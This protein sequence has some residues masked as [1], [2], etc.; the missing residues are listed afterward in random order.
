LR[1]ASGYT[2]PVRIFYQILFSFIFFFLLLTRG[3]AAGNFPGDWGI[4]GE[5]GVQVRSF[6]RDPNFGVQEH[7]T[8]SPSITMEV[9]L[10]KEWNNGRDRF[11][12]IPFGR[13]DAHDDQRSRIEIKELHWTHQ[14][15]DWSLLL[16]ISK[17]FWGVTESRHLVDIIN[18]TDSSA[19][20]DGEDKLGQPMINLTLER[21][22]G[23]I[24]LFLLPYFRE[25]IF[26]K[27]DARLKGLFSVRGDAAYSS[28]LKEWH[29]DWAMRY[30]HTFGEFDLGVS[31]FRGTS[32]EPRPKEREAN[33]KGKTVRAYYET[34]SQFG[35]DLQWTRDSWLWKLEHSVTYGH[36]KTFWGLVA[37]FEH[38]FFQIFD[39]NADL[40]LLAEYL[41][42]ARTHNVF[43]APPSALEH[44]IFGGVRI[45]LNNPADSNLLAGIIMDA[46]DGEVSALV[47]ASHR[48]NQNWVFEVETRWLFA[49]D[50]LSAFHDL[51]RD[52]FISARLVWYF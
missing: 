44:D 46:R 51:R 45:S 4:T 29:P 23:S 30:S 19:D 26:P 17:V 10:L 24:D 5:I 28:S 36:R 2:Q 27:Q 40:G 35:I 7:A 12:F 50:T 6:P 14:E 22:W 11:T 8:I 13:W 42:D 18:Q 9:E 37:G 20:I 1:L 16:G 41:Y 34:I 48:L 3:S 52:S 47:E 49:T 15:E 39:T 25:R 32:R 31:F 38:T 33:S 21:E 43:E